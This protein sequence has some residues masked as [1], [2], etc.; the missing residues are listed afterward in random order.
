MALSTLS[1]TTVAEYLHIEADDALISPLLA[2]AKSYCCAYTGHTLA[3][4]DEYDDVDMAAL[5]WISDMYDQRTEH[6]DK[7]INNP[8][9]ETILSLYSCNLLPKEEEEDE[10]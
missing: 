9:V 2:A 4:L 6:T 5:I 7:P 8:A 10:S 1:A 3:E